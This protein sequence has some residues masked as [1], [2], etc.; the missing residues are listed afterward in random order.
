MTQDILTALLD[1]APD[2]LIVVNAAGTITQVNAQIETLFRYSQDELVGHPLELL[3]P[4]SQ[5]VIHAI[6][7]LHYMQ[8][9]SPRPMGTGQDLAGRHKDGSTFPV[10]ISLRP[11]LI[12]HTLH[13]I[14]AVRGLTAQRLAECECTHI[15]GRLHQQDQLINMAHDAILTRDP[16]SRIR[17]WNQGAEHLYG[18]SVEEARGQ[19]THTLL[20]TR[21]P[22]SLEAVEHALQEHG[23]WEGELTHTCRDGSR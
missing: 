7:Q 1:L 14:G 10:D 21:F 15:T 22:V 18:W 19:V 13:V 11:I 20:Q 6:H 3:L 4:E 8:E 16:E 5:R 9:A 12:G 23:Q 17:S 2:A